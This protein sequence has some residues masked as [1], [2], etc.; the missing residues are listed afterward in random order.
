MDNQATKYSKNFLTTKGCD[1][2]VVEPHNHRVNAAERAIQTFKDAFIVALAMTDSVF[3]L[4]VRNTLT[5]LWKS[6]I[7]PGILAYE[8]LNG[9]CNWDRYL[10]TPPGCKPSFTRPRQYEARGCREV[11]MHGIWGHLKTITY[12]IYIMCQRRK[13]IKCRDL[14][15]CFHSIVKYQTSVV[16]HI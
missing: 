15:S 9:P 6:R 10:L 1:L 14:P 11:P 12:A 3:P 4:Q 7:I 5:L 2:Q 13:H 16:Q 8:A